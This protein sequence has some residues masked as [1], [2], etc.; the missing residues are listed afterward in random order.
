MAFLYPFKPKIRTI[1]KLLFVFAL[2]VFF[3]ADSFSQQYE[4]LQISAI[5]SVVPGGL[6]RSRLI[7]TDEDGQLM[8]KNLENFYSMVGINFKNIRNNDAVIMEKVNELA[9]RGWELFLVNLGV[10]S[11]EKKTGIFI[12]RYIFRRPK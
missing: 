5:E 2:V 4:Y 6:G 7:T 1:K 9:D 12:T 10:E 3:A 8:E 11:S